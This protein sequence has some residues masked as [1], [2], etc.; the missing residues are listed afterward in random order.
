MKP[1]IAHVI[2]SFGL[3][4]VPQVVYQLMRSLPADTYDLYLYVLKSYEDN[5]AA[6]I[7]L[8]ET[9]KRLGVTIR[10]PDRDDKKFYVVSQMARWLI[11]DEIDLLHTHS[12]K[13]NIYGRL[14]GLLCQP[15]G[16][17]LI[18]HY[19][20]YYDNK[21]L[22]DD[23]LIYEQLLAY[24]TDHFLACSGSVAEHVASRADIDNGRIEVLL[25]GIDLSRFKV[26]QARSAVK[27]ELGL[28][29]NCKLV[30][31]VGRL[32]RQKAQDVFLEAAAKLT[33]IFPDV[34]FLLAGAPDEPEML[35]QLKAQAESL[36]IGHKVR[37]LGYLEDIPKIYG[38]LDILVM[39]S[40]WE[41]F[42]LAL[43]EAMAMGLPIVT[44]DVGGI[45][46]VVVPNETALIVPPE[47]AGSIAEAVGRLL[48]APD[49]TAKFSDAGQIRAEQFSHERIGRQ[50]HQC[51]QRLLSTD[52]QGTTG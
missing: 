19:H 44:T 49:L 5:A 21:W 51:Y 38:I 15:K 32:C 4:G 25:N 45:P 37:F 43:V 17:K 27:A 12:Y 48:R 9:F 6:R 39:P 16:V 34:L 40:R 42:G 10:C 2:N 28:P 52:R 22:E 23:S 36:S 18:A 14:A 20:N 8:S 7:Q 26:T 30:G 35:L 50:T 46:E 47:N 29:E 33:E 24:Q 1:K 41:G 3:G 31:V 13:P 11:E